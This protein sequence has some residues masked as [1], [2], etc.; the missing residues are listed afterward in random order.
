M[1]DESAVIYGGPPWTYAAYSAKGKGRSADA[2]Y[3]TVSIEDIAG[4][5]VGSLAADNSASP[6]GLC[7]APTNPTRAATCARIIRLH[8]S[9]GR[10]QAPGEDPYSEGR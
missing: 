7:G 1:T 9:T 8:L 2:H 4:L 3:D 10:L 6:L 5:P